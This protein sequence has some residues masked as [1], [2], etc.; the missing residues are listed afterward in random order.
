MTKAL[1]VLGV[2]ALAVLFFVSSTH[3][4]PKRYWLD[5]VVLDR[6]HVTG[7][8]GVQ[9][10]TVT[11]ALMDPGNAN[12]YAREQKWIVTEQA[13]Y[14]KTHVAVEFVGQHFKACRDGE[15][16]RVYG[17]LVMQYVDDKGKEKEEL[18][19]IVGAL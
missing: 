8:G 11:I 4:G 3:A 12:P 17:F 13:V 10:P 1:K 19:M 5:C 14:S 9:V 7:N 2:V 15:N 16:S 6:G 18:H